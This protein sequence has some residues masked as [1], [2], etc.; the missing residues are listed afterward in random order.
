M[1]DGYESGWKSLVANGGTKAVFRVIPR[2]KVLRLHAI[3]TG[4]DATSPDEAYARKKG[5][6]KAESQHVGRPFEM[7]Q[8]H[9]N[10]TVD[11]K[12]YFGSLLAL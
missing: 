8:T 6:N 11:S 10:L 5:H 7:I 1:P 2:R 12:V 3:T 9:D 4:T